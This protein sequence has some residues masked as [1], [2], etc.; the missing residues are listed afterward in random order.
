MIKP[1]KLE[2]IF[3]KCLV[4]SHFCKYLELIPILCKAGY[5]Y[6]LAITVKKFS[7]S[8]CHCTTYRRDR[9][10]LN[11]LTVFSENERQ[12]GTLARYDI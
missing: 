1:F 5:I 4:R 9:P 10:K 3:P 11:F 6:P 7:A 12:F 8:P 2:T